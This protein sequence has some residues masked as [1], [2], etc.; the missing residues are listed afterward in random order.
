MAA[1]LFGLSLWVGLSG[2]VRQSAH[3]AFAGMAV[4]GA[5][6]LYSHDVMAMPQIC[7]ALLAGSAAGLLLGRSIAK[8]TLPALLAGF[9]AQTGLAA[10][11]LDLGLW[12]NPHAFGLLD[13]RTDGM[14]PDAAIAMGLGAGFG[15]MAFAG[16]M[17]I[18][19]RRM[20][21]IEQPLFASVSLA[22]AGAFCWAFRADG[23]WAWLGG[24]IGVGLAAGHGSA[25]WVLAAGM[26]PALAW[27]GGMA[28]WAV[29]ANAFLLEN[30]G[31]AVAG[32]LAGAAGSLF[33]LRLCVGVGRKGLADAG[34][35]P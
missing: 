8:T 22:L 2:R 19:W 14:L 5:V 17:T 35:H 34:R 18:L 6:T 11:L 15:A 32:G 33:A 7:A 24:C 31:L 10:M 13:D 4:L 16:A 27:V 26:G 21:R 1:L 12:R 3:I 20:R 25:K 9:L 30:M 29:A 28:G 23:Q